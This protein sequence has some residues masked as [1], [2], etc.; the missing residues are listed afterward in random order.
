[1]LRGYGRI[2]IL[3]E[4][5]IQRKTGMISI[6]NRDRLCLAR[7]IAVCFAHVLPVVST[8]DWAEKISHYPGGLVNDEIAMK[9]GVISRSTLKDNNKSERNEQGTMAKYILTL[10]V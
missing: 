5:S 4:K 7:A 6:K 10:A 2:P 9:Q 3:N 8:E 1:M